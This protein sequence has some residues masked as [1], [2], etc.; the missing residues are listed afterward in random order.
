[1]SRWVIDSY[2]LLVYYQNEEGAERV[3]QLLAGRAHEHWMSVV[4]L[5]EV[6]YK[7]LRATPQLTMS[8]FL[9]DVSALPIEFVEA[10]RSMALAAGRIKAH[11]PMAYADCFAAALAQQLDAVVITGDQEFR[12]LDE[13]G[14]ISVEWL[15][16][17]R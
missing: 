12:R 8:E 6:Y 10:D 5:G 13:A 1:M 2:A 4:N 16:R 17:R 14:I 3:E 15:P 9:S 7:L 11:W